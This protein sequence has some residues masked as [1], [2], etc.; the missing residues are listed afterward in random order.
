M[1]LPLGSDSEMGPI[2]DWGRLPLWQ[3]RAIKT[4]VG[5]TVL[6]LLSTLAYHAIMIVFEGRTPR[7]GHSLQVVIETYTGTGYGSDAPWDSTVAN[8]FVAVMDLSTFLLLF[9]VVPYVFRPVLEN[10]L[11][12]TIPTETGATDHV[13]I[14][15]LQHQDRRL[16]EELEARDRDYVIVAPSEADT[17]ALIDEG[18]EAIHGDPTTT[19]TLTSANIMEAETIVV[20]TEDD[21]AASVVLAIRDCDESIR[22]VV[23][24]ETPAQQR[25]LRFA[26]ADRV[27]TPRQ[28]LGRRIG[29]RIRTEISPQHS[30]LVPLGEGVAMVE[31]PVFEDSPFRGTTIHE[32]ETAHDDTVN[33]LAFW[34]EGEFVEAPAAEMQIDAETMLLVAGDEDAIRTLEAEAYKGR[35][36]SPTVVI[37]GYG[38]VGSTVATHLEDTAAECVVV[39]HEPGQDIDVVGDVT[40]EAT[41]QTAGIDDATVYVL[42]ISD[43]DDAILS[44]LLAEELGDDLDILVRINDT[45]NVTK[46]RRAGGDYVLTL[47]EMSGRVLAREVLKEPLLA[48]G[49]QLKTIK[50]SAD[51]FAGAAISETPLADRDCIVVAVERHGELLTDIDPSFSLEADDSVVVVGTDRALD[52]LSS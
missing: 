14:C 30:D 49:H 48:S 12:P 21:R 25:H 19:E 46:V 3:R 10:A 43:D 5:L 9:I 34:H 26:G 4:L 36:D 31:L 18:F 39:D 42:A 8:T 13:L 11:S 45:D 44:V 23:V 17:H 22:T 1:H 16:I 20:D 33:V 7:I 29:Y 52:A 37:A 51:A 40:E 47:P 35:S 50:V 6:M 32:L 38:I 27:L 41:L 15:G 2:I 24:V 28:L